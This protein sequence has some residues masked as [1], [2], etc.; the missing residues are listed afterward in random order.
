MKIY[1]KNDGTVNKN[2]VIIEFTNG[3]V[4]TLYFS[5]ETIV[6]YCYNGERA[7]TVNNWGTTTGKYLNIIEPDHKKRVEHNVL[8][9]QVNKIIGD[10]TN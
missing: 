5:Y 8:L 9:D 6:G 1:L 2:R 7:C 10:N 3:N 4:I